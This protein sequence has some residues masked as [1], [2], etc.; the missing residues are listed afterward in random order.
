[1]TENTKIAICGLG[2]IGKAAARLL[3]DHRSGYDLVAAITKDAKDQ[4]RPLGEVAG[5]R[6]AHDLVVGSETEEVLAAQ[7]DVVLVMTGSFL[8]DTADL[9]QQFAEAGVSVISPCEELAFPFTRDA[10]LAAQLDKVAS[11]SGAT[12][13][14]TGV[15]PGFIFDTFLATASGCSWDVASIRGRRVVDVIGFGEN[16][17]RRLGIGYTPEEFDAGHADG[18]IAGHVGFPESIQIVAERLG[19]TLDGPVEETFE[20]MVAETNAPSGYGGVPAGRTEGFVQR[21]TG[22][23]GGEPK[24]EFELILHL[25]PQA[26]GLEPADT[27]EIEGEHPVRVQLSPGMDAIPATSAQIVNS[28]PGVLGAGPGVK[29][30]KDIPAATAWSDLNTLMLR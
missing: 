18:S 5:S 23:V 30:V 17:H 9:V 13:L 24:I 8:R 29:T 1:M 19:I 3:I 25:R 21:A 10:D 2:S 15:N 20:A 27:F 28:I 26:S 22:R 6:T 16:I 7:P 14:G 12:V 4:G 11:A